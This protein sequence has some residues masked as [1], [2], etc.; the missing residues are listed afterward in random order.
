V[1]L[2][3]RAIGA[4]LDTALPD[5]RVLVI[6]GGSV[7]LLVALCLADAGARGVQLAEVSP[8]RRQTA[9]A[10]G[11]CVAFDPVGRPAESGAF[12]LVVDAVGSTATR[13]ASIAAVR[14]GGVVVH[15][16]LEAAEGGID[17]RRLTRG[18]V[19]FLGSYSYTPDD[20][21]S[22]LAK[23]AAGDLGDLAWVEQRPLREGAA[24]VATQLRGGDVPTK[25]VLVPGD[26]D[27]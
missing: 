4:A 7:G 23:L 27:R 17:A 3:E 12:D 9:E 2:G 26:G 14:D 18:E 22:A 19:W 15:L 8:A 6:G 20:L 13:A 5:A 11:S 16:G 1:R 24:V 10:T 25:V 21:R